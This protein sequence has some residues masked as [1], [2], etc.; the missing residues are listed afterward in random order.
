MTRTPG[1]LLPKQA[2]YQLR[3]TPIYLVLLWSPRL[4]CPKKFMAKAKFFRP[5]PQFRLAL[6]APGG[7]QLRCPKQ[8]RYQLRYTPIYL[9][10]LWSPRLR[11]PKKFM[12][13]A[14]FFRPLPQFRL[15]LSAPGGAQLR[16]PKQ[17]RYQLRYT[18]ISLNNTINY[19]LI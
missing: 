11:C 2:R 16:C 14:K 8:A 10:L 3:Y 5:L 15:A 13:K 4:R 7:A 1:I 12:A 6:S 17:A 18:P 9:V 19:T